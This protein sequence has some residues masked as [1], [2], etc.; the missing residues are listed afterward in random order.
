M[1]LS[2]TDPNSD[3]DSDLPDL[4][5]SPSIAQSIRKVHCVFDNSD[6]DSDIKS[7]Y[8]PLKQRVLNG[9]NTHDFSD[10]IEIVDCSS[11]FSYDPSPVDLSG[12]SNDSCVVGMGADSPSNDSDLDVEHQP[13]SSLISRSYMSPRIRRDL[14]GQC[15]NSDPCVS[16]PH[17]AGDRNHTAVRL[18]QPSNQASTGTGQQRKRMA[19]DISERKRQAQV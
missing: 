8:V 11:R 18:P 14:P 4:E 13:L 1:D 5:T 9:H 2:D 15:V 16:Q 10:G 19:E 17:M 6:S 7:N 12:E 3:A